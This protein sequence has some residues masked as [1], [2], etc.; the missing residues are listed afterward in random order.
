[1]GCIRDEI[2]T[3]IL[4]GPPKVGRDYSF[5]SLPVN[6]SWRGN[7][8]GVQILAPPADAPQS[9]F[10]KAEHPL[11]LEFP[12]I[13]CELWPI[14]NHRR[15]LEHRKLTLLLNVLL[16]GRT[17]LQPR[18]SEH[19]WACVRED[20][21]STGNYQR[22]LS[23]GFLSRVIKRWVGGWS[24]KN[25]RPRDA[26]ST[27]IKWVQ[28]CYF[29]KLGEVVIDQLSPF[30]GELLEE[31]EPEA[32]YTTVGHDGKGLRFP[33]DL[34]DSVCLYF[35]LS[36]SNR[37]KLDRATFWMDMAS[38]QWTVS[39]SSSFASLVSAIES[40]IGHGTTHRV[41]CGNCKTFSQHEVPDATERFRAFFE[42]HASGAAMRSR[43]V[44]CTRFGR[45]FFTEVS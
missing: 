21:E 32:Y 28:Q 42:Q 19:F 29:A 9:P 6:G 37:A 14:T 38:R 16:A 24:G 18:R 23:R 44:R 3:S 30:V 40:L 4:V 43:R 45:V 17:S 31:I 1:M 22:A 33:T 26:Q 2:E 7:R 25:L 36:P 12:I 8:S 39:V 13:G 5:S 20:D 35:Q 11:I 34:D 27:E 41:Y 10:K 15:L